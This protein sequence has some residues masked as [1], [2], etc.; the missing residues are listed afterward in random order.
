MYRRMTN[1]IALAIPFFFLLMGV[2]ARGLDRL[3]VWLKGPDWRPG[4]LRIEA[5]EVTRAAQRKHD[6]RIPAGLV[7]YGRLALGAC[8]GVA[9]LRG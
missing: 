6:P 7:G 9:W 1:Y 4:G 8:V 5:P 2:E 3:R